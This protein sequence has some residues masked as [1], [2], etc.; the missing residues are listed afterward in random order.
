[1]E[2]KQLL[3]LHEVQWEKAKYLKVSDTPQPDGQWLYEVILPDF[4]ASWDIYAVWEFERT[5][6]MAANLKKGDTLFEVGSEK[7]WQAAIYA[8]FVGGENMVLIEPTELYWPNTRQIFEHNN[9]GIPKA[10]FV[11]LIGNDYKM[12]DPDNLT[13]GS[14]PKQTEGELFDGLSYRYIGEN[15]CDQLSIDKF[16]EL[17]GIVPNALN[18]DVE[19]AEGFIFDGMLET[20]KKHKP[21]IWLSIHPDLMM[22]RYNRSSQDIYKMIESVGYT[23]QYLATDHERHELLFPKGYIPR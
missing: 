15:D 23:S 9:L 5:Q 12:D 4:L 22:N 17:T 2:N 21:L 6:S 13:I 18:I 7:C 16:V 3:P 19:G 14:W 8:Q 1:M 10:C 20:L 11:G